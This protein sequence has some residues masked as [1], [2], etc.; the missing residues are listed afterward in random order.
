MDPSPEMMKGSIMKKNLQLSLLLLAVLVV[1]PGR[2]ALAQTPTAS[3]RPADNVNTNTKMLYH[4]GRVM[5]GDQDVYLIWYGC[6]DDS[7]GF[8]GNTTIQSILREFT[9]NIGGSPY[10]PDQQDLPQRS[11]PNT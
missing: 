8:R 9:S 11:W 7:C 2:T 10:L 3:Q 6:W 1:G 4:D 5:V